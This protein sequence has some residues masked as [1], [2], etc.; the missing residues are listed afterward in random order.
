VASGIASVMSKIRWRPKLSSTK[1]R[2]LVSAGIDGNINYWSPITGKLIHS[3]KAD[4]KRSDLFCI[5]YTR[6]SAK[7]AAAGRRRCIKIFDDEKQVLSSK[8]RN[9]GQ[10]VNP[11][12]SNRIFALRF[13][14]AGKQIV[15]ASWDMTVKV[16]D[17]NSGTVARSIYGPEISGDA[18]D[19]HGDVVITGSH[20]SKE[21][22]QLWSLSYGK[23]I[24]T[25]EWDP[26]KPNDSSQLLSAQF[27]KSGNRFIVA[28]GS[29]RNEARVFEKRMDKSYAF[30]CGIVDL[31]S[32]CSSVD[33][34]SKENLI[35][36]GSCDGIC[37]LF[38]KIEKGKRED[39]ITADHNRFNQS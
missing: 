22:L 12:H 34:S 26:E 9:K 23:L 24:D 31:P 16:W 27:E 6:D 28:C 14:E 11:G 8:L 3:I 25:I 30:S 18:L 19:I 29:G 38:E 17:I 35:A 37:R 15:S 5:D 1:D 20:R 4:K 21:A 36:V 13:D 7:L 39:F 2:L 32:A 33:F 10:V